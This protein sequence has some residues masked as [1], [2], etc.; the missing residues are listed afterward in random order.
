MKEIIIATKNPGKIRE[1]EALLNIEDIKWLTYKEVGAWPDLKEVGATY[2]EN[3]LQKARA[4]SQWSGK[5]ILADDSGLEVEILGGRP[6]ILSSR[7]AGDEEDAAKNRQK[8]LKV[9]QGKPHFQRK[10][11]FVCLI[12]L[13][14]SEEEYFVSRGEC[15]G[16]IAFSEKGQGGF[17]Y[18]AIFI[19]EGYNKTMAEISLEEKNEISHR[20]KA[21]KEIRKYLAK[22]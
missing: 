8:L 4:V 3:T 10:A 22:I 7:F 6:G 19:P 18:D 20:A 2:E 12:V 11:K 16:Y 15:Q 17:G 21:L 1:I 14:C 9:L 5:R 13:Y